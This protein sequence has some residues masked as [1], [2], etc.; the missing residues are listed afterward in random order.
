MAYTATFNNPYDLAPEIMV[1][2]ATKNF[3]IAFT[4]ESTE[5]LTNVTANVEFPNGIQYDAGSLNN[6]I[7]GTVQELDVNNLEQISFSISNLVAGGTISFDGKLSAHFDAYQFHTSGGIF[8]NK[9]TVNYLGGSESTETEPY[10]I[11]Y[12]ALTITKVEPLSVTAFVGQTFTRKVTIVN[13]GYGQL[14]T[15]V[16]TDTYDNNLQL[17]GTDKGILNPQGTEITLNSNDFTSIGD[18]DGYSRTKLCLFCYQS[19]YDFLSN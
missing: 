5:T 15:F 17:T 3:T 12:P 13:G 16:L 2:E 6:V 19:K 18:G 4:N 8:R 10:N 1:C 7:G 11:L 9:V 14:T